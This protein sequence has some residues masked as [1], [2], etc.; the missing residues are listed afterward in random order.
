LNKSI[1]TTIK[2]NRGLFDIQILEIWSYRDL[3]WLLIKR[4]FTVFYK[5]TI[6]GPFWFFIQPLLSTIVFTII[7]NKVAGISTDGTP[8]N[9]FYMSGIIA[10]NYFSGCLSE[11]SN[12]FNRNAGLFGKVYFPRI[13]VPLS[14]VISKLTT[15]F[16]QSVL[17]LILHFYYSSNGDLN[18]HFD[19]SYIVLLP[20]MI[21]QMAILGLGLGSI[22]SSLTVKYRDLGFLLGFGTQ[23][24]M[25]ACPIVYPLTS[26][27]ENYKSYIQLN[28]MTPIIIGFRKI[29]TGEGQLVLDI[30]LLSIFTSVFIFFIGL[31][32]F[33]KVE[34]NFIDTI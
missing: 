34:K 4:D 10:W 3:L 29:F 33:S 16:V 26:V 31:I 30:Y 7:F 25:Y 9:L 1:T 18:Y 22:I 12:V 20:I 28:P 6:L 5:Q 14:I 32:I 2:P 21:L 8:P 19:Y 27:P 24:L 23:L 13:V 11:T 15:F 17:L